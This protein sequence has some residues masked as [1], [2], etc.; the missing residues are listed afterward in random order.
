MEEREGAA[1]GISCAAQIPVE[2]YPECR[3]VPPGGGSNSVMLLPLHDGYPDITSPEPDNFFLFLNCGFQTFMHSTKSTEV[4]RFLDAPSNVP[5]K[6]L[7]DFPKI[8]GIFLKYDTFVPSGASVEWLFSRA[9]DVFS[10]KRGKM[11]D[12]N[13]ECQLLLM[14]HKN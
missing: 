3:D 14:C 4:S 7:V 8:H 10:R 9:G 5:M 12:F 6:K 13:F 1:A 2:M 11:T